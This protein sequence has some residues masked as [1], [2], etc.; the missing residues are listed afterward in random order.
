MGSM[1]TSSSS[2]SPPTTGAARGR[3]HLRVWVVVAA[4]F[5]LGLAV[6]LGRPSLPAALAILA[7]AAIGTGAF[8]ACGRP[9]RPAPTRLRPLGLS[10]VFSVKLDGGPLTVGRSENCDVTLPLET[11][12][13]QHCRLYRK[14]TSWFVEDL[15]SRNGT[16]VNGKPVR[17]SRLRPGDTLS[18][19]DFDFR[20]C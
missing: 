17:T 5:L 6:G 15:G 2:S 9:R 11:V 13:S 8:F 3:S 12:S 10:A 4:A 19:A 1:T 18:I 20:V 16:C 14:R 7:A